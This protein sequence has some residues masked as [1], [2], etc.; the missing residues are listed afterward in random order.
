VTPRKASSAPRAH[1]KMAQPA[2]RHSN[3]KNWSGPTKSNNNAPQRRTNQ[4]ENRRGESTSARRFT[5]TSNLARFAS[6][7]ALILC[8][9]NYIIWAKNARLVHPSD[10]SMGIPEASGCLR[11]ARWDAA[12]KVVQRTVTHGIKNRDDLREFRGFFS[13]LDVQC[14]FSQLGFMQGWFFARLV[15]CC[16]CVGRSATGVIH[17][18]QL[19]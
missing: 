16:R 9:L 14:D 19:T 4:L 11:D 15:F 6:A 8:A 12:Y 2:E 1:A 3:K 10:V 17:R 5:L 13:R 7:L 18:A